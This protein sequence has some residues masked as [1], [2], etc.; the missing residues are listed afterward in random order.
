M[1]IQPFLHE[2]LQAAYGEEETAA[3]EAGYAAAR[4]TTLRVNRLKAGRQEI[5]AAL[6]EAG[7]PF[8]PVS[9]FADAFVLPHGSEAQLG[10]L[11]CYQDGK[12]YLQSLSSMLP[13]LLLDPQPGENILDMAAAPGG[14]TTEIASLTG[15]KA[16]ITACE[17]NAARLERMR[18]N[19]SRQG[20]SRVTC[21]GMDARQLDDLFSF[22]RVLLDAP[23][24]GSGTV[25]PESRGRFEPALLK[26]TV[27]LQRALLQKALKLTRKGGILVYST[28]SVLR[29][30]NEENVRALLRSGGCELV[31]VDAARYAEVPQLPVSLP[32]TLLVKPDE[33][34]EGFFAAVIRKTK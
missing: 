13:P 33:F 31:P 12:L 1:E 17:R 21:L 22:D 16:M 18:A 27:S 29:E 6:G 14:K 20:A 26:K 5:E 34:Y 32:G 4:R 15:G 3:I 25:T 23:C 24:S 10:S 2:R 11:P 30:E 28:C 7:L 19:L 8:A 9:L